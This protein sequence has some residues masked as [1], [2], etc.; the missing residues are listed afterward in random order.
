MSQ[1]QVNVSYHENL[2]NKQDIIDKVLK[3]STFIYSKGDGNYQNYTTGCIYSPS[4]DAFLF[5]PDVFSRRT[6]TVEYDDILS[7]AIDEIG[8]SLLLCDST[9]MT[10]LAE[11]RITGRDIDCSSLCFND[12]RLVEDRG[13]I[14]VI[15]LGRLK[16]SNEQI[17]ELHRNYVCPP[18][19]TED[20]ITP[21]YIMVGKT[22]KVGWWNLDKE[23]FENTP[24]TLPK[25]SAIDFI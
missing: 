13:D 12:P 8:T 23:R 21:A 14:K 22:K 16:L 2:F 18:P 1:V 11:E 25:Q 7:F 3:C 17:S 4:R 24:V 6:E 9:W 5:F 19:Y 20:A 15:R 10:G